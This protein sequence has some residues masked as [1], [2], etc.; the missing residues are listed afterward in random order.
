MSTTQEGRPMIWSHT[1]QQLF[2]MSRI[3]ISDNYQDPSISELRVSGYSLDPVW[4]V[5]IAEVDVP[6]T[7]DPCVIIILV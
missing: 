7:S 1:N 2:K 5:K 6:H 4:P 3:S